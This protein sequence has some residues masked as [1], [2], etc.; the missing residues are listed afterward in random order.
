MTTHYKGTSE[1]CIRLRGDRVVFIEPIRMDRLNLALAVTPPLVN[2][3][4]LSEDIADLDI[5]PDLDDYNTPEEDASKS[6]V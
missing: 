5:M 3:P 1:T 6:L 4:I 2:S